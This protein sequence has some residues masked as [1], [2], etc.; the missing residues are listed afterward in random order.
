[1]SL[2]QQLAPVQ[3]YLEQITGQIEAIDRATAGLTRE[4]ALLQRRV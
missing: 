2:E 1:M 4:S 3:A